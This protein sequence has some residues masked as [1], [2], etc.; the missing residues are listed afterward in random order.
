[1]PPVPKTPA[2]ERSQTYALD[3][4]ATGTSVFY[5]RVW[6]LL[7]H[8]CPSLLP[9][10]CVNGK[11]SWLIWTLLLFR[12]FGWSLPPSLDGYMLNFWSWSHDVTLRKSRTK[13]GTVQRKIAILPLVTA[14]PEA[15]TE[16]SCITTEMKRSSFLSR[17]VKFFCACL[18]D[19]SLLKITFLQFHSY[20]KTR[21]NIPEDGNA[22]NMLRLYVLMEATTKLIV[23]WYVVLYSLV[24]RYQDSAATCH[25]L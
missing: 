24:E 3:R 21:R 25:N 23:V 9:I 6:I 12:I 15:L 5:S 7:K 8:L 2:G 16:K 19:W 4:A 20:Q 10:F 1:M 18:L 17:H 14:P 11:N 22:K 13:L